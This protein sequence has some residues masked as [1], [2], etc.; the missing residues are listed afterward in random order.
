MSSV[1]DEVMPI[2][3]VASSHSPEPR[4]NPLRRGSLFLPVQDGGRP[5]EAVVRMPRRR[6]RPTIVRNNPFYTDGYYSH[7]NKPTI[8]PTVPRLGGTGAVSSAVAGEA[9][10][11]ISRI[12]GSPKACRTHDDRY[13][14]SQMRR[15]AKG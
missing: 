10:S 11:A 7:G 9:T 15:W 8:S 3:D 1:V 6:E 13:A 4:R 5:K 2:A 14:G 12:V